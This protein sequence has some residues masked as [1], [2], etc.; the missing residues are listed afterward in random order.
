MDINLNSFALAYMKEKIHE[1]F[2]VRFDVKNVEVMKSSSPRCLQECYL[3]ETTLTYLVEFNPF[4]EINQSILKL[5]LLRAKKDFQLGLP[6]SE[7][8]CQ[9]LMKL[10]ALKNTLATST[11]SVERITSRLGNML[12][13]TLN[14]AWSRSWT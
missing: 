3:D 11:A 8:M 10:V 9:N 5:E 14:K 13:I 12:C 1:E 2:K 7:N 6:I 4:L